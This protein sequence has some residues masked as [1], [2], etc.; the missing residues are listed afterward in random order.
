[1]RIVLL[2]APGAGKGTVAKSLT[3]FDGSVQISTGDILRNAVKAGSELGKK[4]KGYMERGEHAFL[5]SLGLSVRE[6]PELIARGVLAGLEG[7]AARVERIGDRE[8]AIVRAVAEAEA[9]DA[10]LVAGKGH[11]TYQDA[12]GAKRHFD[13]REVV[14]AALA[15]RGFRR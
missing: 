11:E 7:A 14:R 15:A 4:A 2:G 12:G 3:E 9:G 1:M 10:V 5:R 6:D 13:D 8:A